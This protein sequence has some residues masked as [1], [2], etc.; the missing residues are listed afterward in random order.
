LPSYPDEVSGWEVYTAV[1]GDGVRTPEQF[2]RWLAA[3]WSGGGRD[4]N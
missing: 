3:N 1:L 2:A 4:G